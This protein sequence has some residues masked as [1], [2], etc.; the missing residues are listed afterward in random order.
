MTE[1]EQTI[2][3]W[4]EE[5]GVKVWERINEL[6][7]GG[8]KPTD[9]VRELSIPAEKTRSLQLYVQRHGPRRRLVQFGRFKDALLAQ[10]ET[11][12]DELVQALSV[13]AAKAVNNETPTG[14]QIR[15]LEAMTNFVNAMRAMMTDDAKEL[16]QTDVR[17]EVHDNRQKLSDEAISKIKGIYGLADDGDDGGNDRIS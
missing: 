12:G 11:I 14:Q 16:R 2:P 17:V 1:P 13:V 3:R 8:W 5:L 4:A 9:I 7:D 15:G 10:A 6:L